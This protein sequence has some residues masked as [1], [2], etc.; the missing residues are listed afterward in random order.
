MA[1]KQIDHNNSN[2]SNKFTNLKLAFNIADT[3]LP[4]KEASRET[5]ATIREMVGAA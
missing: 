2:I 3:A 4:T 1:E 5:I